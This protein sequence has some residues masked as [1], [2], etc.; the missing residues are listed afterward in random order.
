MVLLVMRSVQV[1][2]QVPER[3]KELLREFGQLNGDDVRK[4]L[5]PL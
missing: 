3:A 2:T 5:M 1:P 4:D